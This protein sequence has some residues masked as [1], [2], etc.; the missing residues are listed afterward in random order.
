MSSYVK[1]KI[2]S[3]QEPSGNASFSPD[4][5]AFLIRRTEEQSILERENLRKQ[6]HDKLREIARQQGVKP[7]RSIK[8]LQGDFWPEDESVDDFL[9]LVRAIRHQ[10]KISN[11]TNE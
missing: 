7:I 11:R 9:E 5:Y 8:E 4:D 10:D 2:E 6:K 3:L 1:S